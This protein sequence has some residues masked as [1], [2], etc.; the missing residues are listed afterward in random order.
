MR[1]TPIVQQRGVL[2]NLLISVAPF[3]LLILFYVWMIKRQ[4]AALGGGLFG[5]GARKPVDPETVRVTI[6]TRLQRKP[7][8]LPGRHSRLTFGAEVPLSASWSG[9]PGGE[10]ALMT[11]WPMSAPTWSWTRSPASTSPARLGRG[12]S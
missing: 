5:G 4:R 1:A 10:R 3:L 2:W 8:A 7:S 6:P 11:I 9:I 12:T